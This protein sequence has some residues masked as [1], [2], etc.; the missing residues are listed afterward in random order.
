MLSKYEKQVYNYHFISFL[1]EYSARFINNIIDLIHGESFYIL[2]V[3]ATKAIVVRFSNCLRL[4]LH[5][6]K[7][8]V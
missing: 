8:I 2:A 7:C 5:L 1:Y 6:E 4:F 3:K